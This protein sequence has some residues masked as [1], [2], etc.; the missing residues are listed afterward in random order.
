M[1]PSD[2]DVPATPV[3]NYSGDVNVPCNEVNG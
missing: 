3:V 2:H 1:D